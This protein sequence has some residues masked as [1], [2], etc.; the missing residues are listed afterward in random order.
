MSLLPGVP[1]LHCTWHWSPQLLGDLATLL[2]PHRQAHTLSPI[3][4]CLHC[5]Y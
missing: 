4:V 1:P 3:T 2:L 5:L